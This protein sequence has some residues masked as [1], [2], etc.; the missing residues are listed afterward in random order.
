MKKTTTRQGQ[1]RSLDFCCESNFDACE[2]QLGGTGTKIILPVTR[3]LI[4]PAWD[5]ISAMTNI[6]FEFLKPKSR[7]DENCR[8]TYPS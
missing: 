6:Y 4:S 8:F 5:K 7:H 1:D 3:D 2:S